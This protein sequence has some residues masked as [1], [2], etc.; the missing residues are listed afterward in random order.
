MKYL[1]NILFLAASIGMLSLTSCKKWLDVRPKTEVKES[2]QFSTEQGFKDAL[3]G[4]YQ[5]AAD[6]QLYGENLTFGFL[7]VLSQGYESTT[8]IDHDFFYSA[9]YQYNNAGVTS[10]INSIWNNMY[11]T[12]AQTNYILKNI[13]D[14]KSLFTGNNYSIIRGE[15]LA[16][17][18]FLHFDLLRLYAPSPKSD[19]TA[20]AIPYMTAFTV[21]PQARLKVGEVIA[22]CEKDLKEAEAL[23]RV[24]PQ[25]SNPSGNDDFLAFRSNRMNY[26]AV[27]AILARL[28]L[29]NND[30]VHALAYA[31]D[32]INSNNFRFITSAELN[33]A[34]KDL[35][36]TFTP[37]HIFAIYVAKLKDPVSSYFMM[38]TGDKLYRKF[39]ITEDRRKA[40]FEVSTGGGT[41]LRFV[42][43]SLWSASNG[44]IFPSKLWQ[45]DENREELKKR[46]PVLT[47]SEMY[48]I[49]AESEPLTA[50]GLKWLNKVRS[51][52][53]IAELP[54]GIDATTLQN[55]IF[56]EY[57]KDFICEGQLFYY[58]KRINR[59]KIEGALNSNISNDQYVLPLPQQEIEF[60]K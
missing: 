3:Y 49:A 39:T 30:R 26:W 24:Y 57:R 22:A 13:D 53:N 60:G 12:I 45:I 34:A 2:E 21:T 23:L 8:K 15:A 35:N 48:Y 10:R 19:V 47:L 55:E 11:S 32:I 7:E 36:R 4:T 27:K 43:N 6:G 42:S 44:I 5:K 25:M 51:A 54:A 29:Y 58:Y 14:R 16:L 1:H 52:R 17:R 9:T 59:N 50:D 37:E 56:K 46:I 41:D 31:K 20:T 33:A 40:L 28:Y 38:A 18:A